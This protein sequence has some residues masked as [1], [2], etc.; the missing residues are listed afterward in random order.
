[1]WIGARGS[2]NADGFESMHFYLM[3][4]CLVI[5]VA[6]VNGRRAKPVVFVVPA[7]LAALSKGVH[8]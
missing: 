1:L 6:A 8:T 4:L 7:G 5:P 3:A 2:P